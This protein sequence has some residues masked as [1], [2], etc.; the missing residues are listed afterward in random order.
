MNP[1][2]TLGEEEKGYSPDTP[3]ISTLPFL[4][5][6][7]D[8]TS[9]SQEDNPNE[10]KVS[11]HDFIFRY[12]FTLDPHD[13][14]MPIK[15][16]PQYPYIE[17]MIETWL[18][19]DLLLILKSRQ[20]MASWLFVALM[21]WDAMFNKGRTIFFVSKKEQDAGF[22]SQLS[23]LSR[24]LF[25]YERLPTTLKIP[26]KKTLKP[27]KLEFPD[28]HSS[29]MGMSQDSEGLRQYT[30]S[31]ILSDEMAFQERAEQAYTAMKPTLDG[32][33]AL[34][35]ISTPNGRHNLFY[36][37]VNDLQ[38]GKKE[39]PGSR[40]TGDL[41]K[42]RF[43]TLCKGLSLRRNRN[44]FVV[45]ALHH[46]ANPKKDES[47]AEHAKKSYS[48]VDAWRQEQELDF[49]KTEGTRVFP[50][51]RSDIHIKQLIHNP[52][53]HIWR[54]WDFGYNHPACVWVQEND[55]VLYV[56]HEHLGSEILIT[57]FA[58]EVREI[59]NRLFPGATFRDAGD[60]A[61]NF[62]NDKTERT[63]IDILR[64]K[65]IRV[66]MKKRP[67]KDGI[68]IIRGLLL[69]QEGMKTPR[70]LINTS[71]EN[72]IDGFLG[73]YTREEDDDEPIKDGYYE[74]LFDAL[75]YF[76]N[77]NYDP[78]TFKSFKLPQVYI[79]KVRAT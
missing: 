1:S 60:P 15:R 70:L 41:T 51:F 53:R 55:G 21:L 66:A 56:L 65:G 79:P 72:L 57:D 74:H 3:A 9:P 40:I 23:L 5:G 26:Y 13:K 30:A 36:H 58:D 67:V 12:V 18:K 76:C 17:K 7:L 75:R 37:L 54:G 43:E 16:F 69:P 10:V 46:T 44:G 48:S 68:Q 64:K 19:E 50:S 45:L 2:K 4:K 71:C 35:G 47:W 6:F 28:N 42:A 32:G 78:R 24:A 22:D 8:Y 33:G 20:M 62:K 11:A 49:N 27:P 61:G 73:G 52:Y 25:I 77:V 39:D 34:V 29:I 63:S 14:K 31:R 59:S 38:R